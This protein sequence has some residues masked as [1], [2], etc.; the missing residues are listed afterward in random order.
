MKINRDNFEKIL[1]IL[2]KEIEKSKFISYDLE[3]TGTEL[4]KRNKF[5]SYDT[6]QLKHEKLKNTAQHFSVLQFGI[7]LFFTTDSPKIYEFD[8]FKDNHKTS[9]VKNINMQTLKFFRTHKLD[10]HSIIEKGISYR[11]KTELEKLERECKE[12]NVTKDI[13]KTKF[14]LEMEGRVN[15]WFKSNKWTFVTNRLNDYQIWA[16][17]Q[18]FDKYREKYALFKTKNEQNE[19]VIAFIR[20]TESFDKI[21]E[22]EVAKLKGFSTVIDMIAKKPIVGFSTLLDLYYIW[23]HFISD[24]PETVVEFKKKLE[25]FFIGGI[26]DMKLIAMKNKFFGQNN[27]SLSSLF[28]ILFDETKQEHHA[29]DDSYMTGMIFTKA[30]GYDKDL[31]E[32]A[33][34]KIF[35]YRSRQAFIIH[36]PEQDFKRDYSKVFL[37][38]KHP[39]NDY[40]KKCVNVFKMIKLDDNYTILEKNE[41]GPDESLNQ[42]KHTMKHIPGVIH[43]EEGKEI[44]SKLLT[45]D[46]N[47]EKFKALINVIELKNPL[48]NG[49]SIFHVVVFCIPSIILFTLIKFF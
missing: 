30:L 46:V 23:Q 29:G 40:L 9:D 48:R 42:L 26:F 4:N 2:G 3:F 38:K 6:M 11:N 1:P 36:K 31:F 19:K 16:C 21:I 39:E 41:L 47:I 20:V 14:L 10:I 27:K 13:K 49:F 18:I 7:T 25:I 45:R 8:L 15:E 34:N 33:K 44:M 28:K 12:Q 35:L 22:K 17:F 32:K 5:N 37:V 24:I 43:W